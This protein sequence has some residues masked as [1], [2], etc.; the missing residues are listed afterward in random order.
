MYRVENDAEVSPLGQ[1]SQKSATNKQQHTPKKTAQ[2]FPIRLE[3]V[4]WASKNTAPEE[5]ESL[6]LAV[7]VLLPVLLFCTRQRPGW[8]LW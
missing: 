7:V 6:Q 5:M 1:K 2:D 8:L 4:G 3:R